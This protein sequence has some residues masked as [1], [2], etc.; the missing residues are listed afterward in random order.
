MVHDCRGVG[1]C[2][3]CGLFRFVHRATAGVF[4]AFI[5]ASDSSRFSQLSFSSYPLG[6]ADSMVVDARLNGRWGHYLCAL[7]VEQLGSE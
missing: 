4:I 7:H 2:I 5:S 3:F 6:S 1:F